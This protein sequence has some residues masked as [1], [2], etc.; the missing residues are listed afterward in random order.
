MSGDVAVLEPAAPPAPTLQ[1]EGAVIL[2]MIDRLMSRPDVPVEKLEQMFELH[3][4]IK[5]EDAKRAFLEAFADLQA[6]L[7]AA[8]RRGTGHNSKKYAR[9]EDVAEALREPLSRCGFS[10]WFK[11]EQTDKGVKITT[12]L[13]HR[14]GH[15]E[16]TDMLLPL[17]T[18]GGKTPMHAFGSTVSYGKRYGLLT[19]T[20]VATDDDD[21]GKKATDKPSGATVAEIKA[22][23]T[24]TKSDATWFLMHY[25][26]E[27]LDD[28][29]GK[30]RE[31]AK[32][33]LIGKLKKLRE[34]ANARR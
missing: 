6:D 28:L 14:A 26:V 9:Y 25:S 34:T 31:Q 29:D 10:H 5:A 4:K 7:P 12:C 32:A 18:S 1:G 30:Q 21:D 11:I 33:M 15:I 2:G 8:A 24:D 23:I 16:T 27:T 17:D 13:G 22:L 3:R 20:G 19:I